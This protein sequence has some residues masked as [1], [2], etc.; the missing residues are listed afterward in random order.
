MR[1]SGDDRRPEAPPLHPTS[2]LPITRSH[3]DY[4]IPTAQRARQ[5]YPILDPFRNL[6]HDGDHVA[7]L[8]SCDLA[9]C[10]HDDGPQRCASPT[11]AVNNIAAFS[12]KHSAAPNVLCF[13]ESLVAVLDRFDTL[14]LAATLSCLSAVH[15]QPTLHTRSRFRIS[16][17]ASYALW[18]TAGA[19]SSAVRDDY[20]SERAASTLRSTDIVGQQNELGLGRRYLWKS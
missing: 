5:C 14:A 18:A 2:Y 10:H 13:Q 3:L 8:V 4:G 16:S 12:K 7:R 11:T 17:R 19:V 20:A 9:S 1:P 15:L 6:D